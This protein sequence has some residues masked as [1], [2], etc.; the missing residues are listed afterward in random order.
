MAGRIKDEDI[1]LVR[2]RSRIEDV[3]GA[4][5]GLRPAGGG[6]LKGLCPFHDEKSPSFN[7]NPPRAS[8]TASA[9][10]RVATSST[11]S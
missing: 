2:E 6:S 4:Q 7:V 3:I 1:A 11:S 9:A 10:V 5:V 8:S